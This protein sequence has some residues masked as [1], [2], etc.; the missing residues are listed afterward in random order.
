M[1]LTARGVLWRNKEGNDFY[2]FGGGTN[3]NISAVNY[4]DDPVALTKIWKFGADPA[5]WSALSTA[6][7]GN[8][9]LQYCS[10]PSLDKSF[11]LGSWSGDSIGTS[12]M[13]LDS[14]Q[15]PEQSS[16]LNVAFDPPGVY[17]KGAIMHLPLKEGDGVLL[18]IGGSIV[19]SSGAVK[20]NP[21]VSMRSG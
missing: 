14:S 5:G 6:L 15:S 8:W 4:S 13:V 3:G 16:R 7:S 18:F 12:L 17:E 21:D 11:A 10:V 2:K 9:D 20:G 1:P 19:P